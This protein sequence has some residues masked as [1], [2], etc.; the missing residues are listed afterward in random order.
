MQPILSF[1]IHPQ[2]QQHIDMLTWQQ[3]NELVA[4]VS[5]ISLQEMRDEY[6]K[7]EEYLD[8]IVEIANQK[9]R[10]TIQS[11]SVMDQYPEYIHR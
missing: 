10:T 1:T 6:K 7:A 5:Q 11:L 9:S 4:H 3:K 2:I 8:Y